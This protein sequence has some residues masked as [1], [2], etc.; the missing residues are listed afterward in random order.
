MNSLAPMRR[1]MGIWIGIAGLCLM[2]LGCDRGATAETPAAQIDSPEARRGADARQPTD[3]PPREEVIPEDL[4]IG[5]YRLA[6]DPIIDGD[7]IR[8]EGIEGS[9]RLLSL[10]TEEKLHGEA[11]RAAA[12]VAIDL[13][14]QRRR[15]RWT[16][17]APRQYARDSPVSVRRSDYRA[18]AR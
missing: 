4:R 1:L 15:V 18:P 16:M 3:E 14:G 8:V 12:A 7:T 5:E 9:L 13:A 6:D 2:G 17:P 10:D 11:D